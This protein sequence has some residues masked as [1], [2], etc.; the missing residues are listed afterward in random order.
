MALTQRL[1]LRQTQSLVM[2]PQLQQAIRL[3]Q[4]SSV[5]VTAFVEQELERNPLLERAD[6]DPSAL[7]DAF[8]EAPDMA[9]GAALEDRLGAERVGTDRLA[10]DGILAVGDATPLD[11][12]LTNVWNDTGPG[13]DPIDRSS[14][15]A[16]DNLASW[17]AR[18]ADQTEDLP[19]WED[20]AVKAVGL[21]EHLDA[22]MRLSIADGGDRLIADHLIDRLDDAGYLPD[23]P[24]TLAAELGCPVDSV[25]RVLSVL[26]GLDPTGVFARD[27]PDC[28]GLQLAELNR[29]DPAMQALL[30]NLG[31]LADRQFARLEGLCGVDRDD[32]VDMLAELRALNPKP[33]LTYSEEPAQIVVPDVLMRPAKEGGW[34]VELNPDALP[35]VLVNQ[36]YHAEVQ[37]AC[38]GDRPAREYLA[39]CLA[40]ATWLV[41]A[42]H[43]RATTILKVSTEIVR[44]QDAFFRHGISQM[45]PLILRDIAEVIGMHESTVSRVT[46]NKYMAT[47]RGLFELKYFFSASIAGT[48]GAEAHSAEAV[49]HRIKALVDAETPS[50]ILS[51]DRIVEILRQDGVE[52]ARRTVAKYRDS[53]RIP[54]SVQRRKLKTRA[55]LAS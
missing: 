52:I 41:K 34:Y 14:D 45:R 33:G 28:L 42:L 10:E 20:R 18:S 15:A 47:P 32:L 31:L 13:D 38:N 4:L 5:E 24:D 37:V 55:A 3:L 36:S 53:L 54:S 30:A 23:P 12:D 25:K 35:R 44:Q 39:E 48:D 6:D 51:D 8:A 27:L 21:R 11:A 26:R 49:R 40:S 16:L 46:A 29:L 22:Q 2:T 17:S 50:D 1:D 7:A 9:P 43:Q 19:N